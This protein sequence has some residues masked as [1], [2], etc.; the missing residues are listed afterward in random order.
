MDSGP[1]K[2]QVGYLK[3][4]SELRKIKSAVDSLYKLAERIEHDDQPGKAG[5]PPV[6][7]GVPL[8]QFLQDLPKELE[9]VG[10]SIREVC[11]RIDGLLF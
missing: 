9:Q 1:D 3:A 7:I 6:P 2:K 10:N 5:E 4:Q 8:A 11:I